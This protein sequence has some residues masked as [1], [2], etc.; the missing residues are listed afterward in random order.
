MYIRCRRANSKVQ[1]VVISY[2]FTFWVPC[3]DVHYDFR[4]KRCSHRLYLKLFIWGF[5]SYLRY[6]C[7]FADVGVPQILTTWEIWWVSCYRQ[8]LLALRLGSPP[9]V[10][11]ARVAPLFGVL[12]CLSSSCV[13]RTQCVFGLSLRDCPFVFSDVYFPQS[14]LQE[15][16]KLHL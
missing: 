13:L 14:Q 4:I 10:G 15:T 9:I 11:G 16:I 6:L 3:C 2:D 5:M 1:H 12:F 7:L 8:G